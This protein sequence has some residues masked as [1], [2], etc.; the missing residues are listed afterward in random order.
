MP[1]PADA[2]QRDLVLNE[3]EERHTRRE[4]E[5][6]ALE[7][8]I[9]ILYNHGTSVFNHEGRRQL[10]EPLVLA[11]Q[12][13][14]DEDLLTSGALLYQPPWY[15]DESA[16]RDALDRF[17]RNSF[18]GIDLHAGPDPD[19]LESIE[20]AVPVDVD[21]DSLP[22]VP[23]NDADT[24]ANV[25]EPEEI[26]EPGQ[27]IIGLLY[28]IAEE[29]A[30]RQA[31]VHRGT[32]CDAC[33]MLPIRGTRWHCINCP[34]YDLCSACE[35]QELIHPRTHVFAKIKIPIPTLAQPHYVHKSWYPGIGGFLTDGLSPALRRRLV[36]E[37]GFEDMAIDANFEQFCCLA[38][39]NVSSGLLPYAVLFPPLPQTDIF[40]GRDGA[41]P[42]HDS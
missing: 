39:K 32:R 36:A 4:Y 17:L 3:T 19:H 15:F 34:D 28:H 24:V 8:L 33:A 35:S 27:G 22:D 11:L 37:T 21:I 41:G 18:P 26:R 9:R 16:V 13:H 5:N 25:S 10:Y 12:R 38:D 20:L 1:L 31:Y 2:F 42:G 29:E 6:L 14:N 23:P 30:K 40:L 7:A